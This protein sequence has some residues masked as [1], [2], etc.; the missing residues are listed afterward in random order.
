MVSVQLSVETGGPFHGLDLLVVMCFGKN[1]N[2]LGWRTF[3][4][5]ILHCGMTCVDG[6]KDIPFL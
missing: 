6:Q 3:D 4:S 5:L 1:G 2:G